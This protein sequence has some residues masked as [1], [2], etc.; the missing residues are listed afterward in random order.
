M[1]YRLSTYSDWKSGMILPFLKGKGSRSEYSNYRAITL[2][3]VPGKVY[4][5]VLLDRMKSHLQH[6][7]RKEQSG[8]APSIEKSDNLM[9]LASVHT[10]CSKCQS[11]VLMY[12]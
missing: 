7:R 5:R 4:A 8:F 9:L 10:A 6:F 1:G 3:S 11:A 12:D 2:L